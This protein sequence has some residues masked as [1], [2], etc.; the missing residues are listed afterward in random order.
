[1]PPLPEARVMTRTAEQHRE[2][3]RRWA[4]SPARQAARR[5][6]YAANVASRV[7]VVEWCGKPAGDQR[8]RCDDCHAYHELA[9]HDA[10]AA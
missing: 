3:N 4:T 1:M 8:V 6:R 10:E 5:A 2:A 7:C 9:K